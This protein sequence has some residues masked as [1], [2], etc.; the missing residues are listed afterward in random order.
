[1]C[2]SAIKFLF[3]YFTSLLLGIFSLILIRNF[4]K[5]CIHLCERYKQLLIICDK[6]RNAASL[7][8]WLNIK[9]ISKMSLQDE[10]RA[11]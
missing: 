9:I 3:Y 6:I 2:V 7:Y 8:D 1:M 5:K 4:L 11:M 10:E